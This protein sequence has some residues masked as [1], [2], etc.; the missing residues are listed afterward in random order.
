MVFP[1]SIDIGN[2]DNGFPWV[3]LEGNASI[4]K[5]ILRFL[6]VIHPVLQK[7]LERNVCFDYEHYKLFRTSST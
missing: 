5:L 1:L 2:I 4:G 3:C 6:T 7:T